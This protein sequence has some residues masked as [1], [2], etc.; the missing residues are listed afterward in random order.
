LLRAGA[1]IFLIEQ[2]ERGETDVGHLLFVKSEALLGPVVVG[3]RHI[4]RGRRRCG[5]APQ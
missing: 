4:G 1:D 5:R 3:L 2:M